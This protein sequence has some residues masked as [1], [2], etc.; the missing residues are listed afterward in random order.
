M[1]IGILLTVF[2]LLVIADLFA[3]A[4]LYP[5]RK[6]YHL[7]LFGSLISFIIKIIKSNDY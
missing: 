4:L 2:V 5:Y 6:W 3:H 7:L 1:T